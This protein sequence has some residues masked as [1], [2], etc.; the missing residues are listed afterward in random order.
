MVSKKSKL[1]NVHITVRHSFQSILFRRANFEGQKMLSSNCF[2][3]SFLW[4]T[5]QKYRRNILR[6]T[7]NKPVSWFTLYR[8]L[9]YSKQDDLRCIWRRQNWTKYS[10]SKKVDGSFFRACCE[11]LLK[12]FLLSRELYIPLCLEGKEEKRPGE[13]TR[14][15]DSWK[16]HGRPCKT[17]FLFFIMDIYIFNFYLTKM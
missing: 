7:Y 14:D 8:L 12:N 9:C 3:N 10:S 15:I 6:S 13:W 5:C 16:D 11:S 2:K 1:W 17:E 4:K